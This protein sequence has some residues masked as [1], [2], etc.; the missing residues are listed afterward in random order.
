VTS[1]P[2][3]AMVPRMAGAHRRHMSDQDSL[4]LT[5]RHVIV[6]TIT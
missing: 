5:Y 2:P 1:S 6:P 4:H 3:G